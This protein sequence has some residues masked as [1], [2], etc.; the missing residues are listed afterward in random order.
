MARLALADDRAAGD[1]EG[2]EQRGGAVTQVI[3]G[4]AFDVAEAHRQQRLAA[5]QGLDLAL[6]VDAQHDGV[7]GRVQIQAD[8]IANLLDEEGIGGQLEVFLAVRLHAEPLKPALHGAL[9]HASVGG[10]AAHAPVGAARRTGLEG[11]VDHVGDTFVLET[12][13]PAGAQLIVQAFDPVLKIA[14]PPLADRGMGQSHALGDRAIGFA[15]GAGEHD[16]DPAHQPMRQ[17]A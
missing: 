15:V 10:Q 5:L 4:H 16:L 14:L 1:V 9:G 6:L 2:G 8:D 12:A 7:V 3:V 11:A 17:R 13:W